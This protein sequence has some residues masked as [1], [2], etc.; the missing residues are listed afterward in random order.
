MATTA[1]LSVSL[2]IGLQYPPAWIFNVGGGTQF[3]DQYG[4]IFTGSAASG[5][6]IAN[7]VTD[8]NVRSQLG[9]YI[10]YLGSHL[11]G[12]NSVR[13]GGGAYNELR[14]PSGGSGSINNVYW[15]YDTSSQASLP[16]SFQGRKPGTGNATQATEFL[17]AII[18]PW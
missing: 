11:T 5:N 16:S 7:A 17:N 9:D 1:G 13:L 15:F 12:V 18:Q 6:D 14:Y 8:I 4:D 2:D 3:I 10:S